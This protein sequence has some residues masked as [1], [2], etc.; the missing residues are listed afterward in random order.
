VALTA[1]DRA[2]NQAS[3]ACPYTIT[4]APTS[5]PPV[6][7]PLAC[8]RAIALSDVTP[9]GRRVRL[10]GVARMRHAGAPVEIHAGGR[11]V[12]GATVRADGTF[13]TTAPRPHGPAAARTRYRAIVA[14]HRSPALRLIRRALTI[15]GRQ[16]TGDKIRV[17]GRLRTKSGARRRL[18]IERHTGCTSAVITHVVTVRTR[19]D[20]SFTVVLDTPSQPDTL[21]VYRVHAT[22]PVTYALPIILR[23]ARR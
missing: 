2:G 8:T 5:A 17:T 12:A 15:T 9:Q 19:R 23:H 7:E 1:A 11:V 21:A 16:R 22:R 4:F 20:G 18:T 13:Q 3:A 6:S 14:G 10:G